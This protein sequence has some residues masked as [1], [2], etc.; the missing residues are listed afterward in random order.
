MNLDWNCTWQIA[1]DKFMS[2]FVNYSKVSHLFCYI[3][4]RMVV[5]NLVGK[6]EISIFSYY[7]VG[8][9]KVDKK[10]AKRLYKSWCCGRGNLYVHA[11]CSCFWRREKSLGKVRANRVCGYWLLCI[12]WGLNF[13]YMS[14]WDV[15]VM[16]VLTL[17]F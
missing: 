16:N 8:Y 11:D 6:L 5:F 12:S 10:G 9:E 4:K 7:I 14:H 3:S 13:Q 1:P 15:H 17:V 2:L